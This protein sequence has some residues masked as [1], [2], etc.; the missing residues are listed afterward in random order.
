MFGQRLEPRGRSFT[1]FHDLINEDL[2]SSHQWS[3]DEFGVPWVQVKNDTDVLV[4]ILVVH[5][6]Q[7][8][9]TRRPV[10]H[11][12]RRD[13]WSVVIFVREV[14]DLLKSE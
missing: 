2:N 4:A 9:N 14:V 11:M 10:L 12:A 3:N 6:L 13:L 8:M 5:S 7:Q 1:D